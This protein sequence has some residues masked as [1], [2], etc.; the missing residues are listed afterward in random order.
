M[1]EIKTTIKTSIDKTIEMDICNLRFSASSYNEAP[2]AEVT[3]IENRDA[4]GIGL[5]SSSVVLIPPEAVEPLVEFL[6]A[7]L[8]ET[9]DEVTSK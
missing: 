6:E 7:F 8:K 1:S 3:I 2:M 9:K 5:S 4:G